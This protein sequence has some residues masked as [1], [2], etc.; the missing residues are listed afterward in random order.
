MSQATF[1]PE[2]FQHVFDALMAS[3]YTT[4]E[5]LD[6][7]LCVFFV[8]GIEVVMIDLARAER[9]LDSYRI[10]ISLDGINK[11]LEET[12]GSFSRLLGVLKEASNDLQSL[13]LILI[14]AK[15]AYQETL[16]S[17]F[18]S[19]EEGSGIDLQTH[20]QLGDLAFKQFLT[21]AF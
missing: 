7:E 17:R 3:N 19:W 15:L 12:F 21:S 16:K 14:S 2:I 11:R 8:G 13:R 10:S 1:T 4:Y 5:P 20:L 18:E 6:L 9:E